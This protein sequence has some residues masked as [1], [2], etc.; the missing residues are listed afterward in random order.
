MS[1]RR[2]ARVFVTVGDS[3]EQIAGYYSLNATSFDKVELP[4]E[5]AKRPPKYPV[6]AAVL[7]RLAVSETGISPPQRRS[8]SCTHI[9]LGPGSDFVGALRILLAKNEVR[10]GAVSCIWNTS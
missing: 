5:L 6:P 7:G 3:P 1:G 10:S 4:I 2:L 9:L 8:P